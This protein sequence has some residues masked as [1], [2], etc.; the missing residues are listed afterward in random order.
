MG[1]ASLLPQALPSSCIAGMILTTPWAPVPQHPQLQWPP[2]LLGLTVWLTVTLI[3]T[4]K[5]P[6]WE[7]QSLAFP[8]YSHPLIFSA[9]LPHC[10]RCIS[11]SASSQL[12]ASLVLS[13]FPQIFISF[14]SSHQIWLTHSKLL[15][16]VLWPSPPPKILV[17]SFPQSN[18]VLV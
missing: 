15:L 16:F 7:S 10:A 3:F 13:Q 4:H 8:K 14:V 17:L 6:A 5:H 18:Y 1:W 2:L 12:Q 9:L 11:L